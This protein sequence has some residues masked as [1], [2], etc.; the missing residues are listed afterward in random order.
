MVDI[1]FVNFIFLCY[2]ILPSRRYVNIKYF[3]KKLFTEQYKKFVELVDV[4]TKLMVELQF[5]HLF[6]I[7]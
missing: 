4:V 3:S 1:V 6:E 7:K 5:L 2:I